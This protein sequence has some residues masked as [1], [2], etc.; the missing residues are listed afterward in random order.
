MSSN[1]VEDMLTEYIDGNLSGATFDRVKS[2]LVFCTNCRQ[3]HHDILANIAQLKSTPI[4]EASKELEQRILKTLSERTSTASAP[5][6]PIRP[7]WTQWFLSFRGM[8]L[9]GAMVLLIF[10]IQH[11]PKMV[12]ETQ[13]QPQIN[14]GAQPV[15]LSNPPKKTAPEE[16]A[17]SLPDEGVHGLDKMPEMRIPPAPVIL[18]NA[19]TVA[20]TLKEK[21]PPTKSAKALENDPSFGGPV[22]PIVIPAVGEGR[23][24][25]TSAQLQSSLSGK[26]LEISDIH[27]I[28]GTSSGIT[29]ALEKVI[30]DRKTWEDVWNRHQKGANEKSPIPEIDFEKN[31]IIAVFAGNQPTAG[32]RTEITRVLL[33]QWE[34]APARVIRYRVSAPPEGAM[35]ATVVTQPF[36]FKIVPKATGPTFFRKIR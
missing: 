9:A 19:R 33:T 3:L 8:S 23:G 13:Q 1:H 28:S 21:K 25:L 10:V 11:A 17:D 35:M 4:L 34:N 15:S 7:S 29:Q 26:R 24:D 2:H 36:C 20:E 16:Y 32:F 14:A 27:V 5:I 31:E 12:K 6:E 22:P 30:S 18:P